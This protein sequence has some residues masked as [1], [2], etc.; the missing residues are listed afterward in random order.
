MFP[1]LLCRIAALKKILK[2][3]MKAPVMESFFIII[4]VGLIK[5]DSTTRVFRWL[6]RNFSVHFFHK[7]PPDNCFLRNHSWLM[8]RIFSQTFCAIFK[9]T[10]ISTTFDQCVAVLLSKTQNIHRFI[11][12]KNETVTILVFLLTLW[13]RNCK[14]YFVITLPVTN[15]HSLP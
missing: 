8:P 1:Y 3:Y 9:I 7:I 5:K 4:A 15:N 10:I 6:L 2:I 12:R 13:I 14:K 11:M